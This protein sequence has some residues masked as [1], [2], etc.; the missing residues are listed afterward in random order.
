MPSQLDNQQQPISIL[1]THYGNE[2]IRGSERCLL[3]LITHIDRK[4]FN[5]IVWCNCKV[6]ADAARKLNVTT[7]HT[8]FPLLFGWHKPRFHFSAFFSLINFGKYLIEEHNVKMIHANSGAPN[9]WL[10]MVSRAMKVPLVAHLHSCYPLRDRLTLGLHQVA[11]TVGVSQP[12]I[13]QLLDDGLPQ[14]RTCVIPNGID[15][16]RL[17]QQTKTDLRHL[18]SF[19]ENDFVIAT[20][21]SLIHR[22]GTDLIIEAIA[23]LIAL[24][25]PARLVIIGDGP[26]RLQLQKQIQWLD[27]QRNII[28]MG[29]RTDVSA[30]LKGADLY[31]S[32]AREEVFGLVLAEASL[33]GLAVVAPS[34]G[35]IPDVVIKG[36][37]GK[38]FAA[39]DIG[40]LTKAMHMF[41]HS[42]EL[43]NEMGA[44]GRQHVINNF[45]IK[46]NTRDFERLYTRMLYEPEMH[47]RWNSHWQVLHPLVN[48]TRQVLGKSFKGLIHGH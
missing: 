8:D 33:A 19:D 17:E 46:R 28:L 18:L 21:G 6:M 38:L 29:E 42:P 1:F 36:K 15:I 25:I 11:M 32:A 43:R 2:W 30:L 45:S 34:L 7:Y 4:K 26:E 27:I 44:A 31:V 9:Q 23:R 47:M 20:V 40:A 39:E 35:G 13:N 48:A 16:N 5:P 10:N 12:V 22:K 37:T 41:Y 14:Q 24:G 3:D